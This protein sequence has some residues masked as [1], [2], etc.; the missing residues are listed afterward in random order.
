MLYEILVLGLLKSSES[1]SLVFSWSPKLTVGPCCSSPA[2]QQG[3]PFDPR[4][5]EICGERSGT[6]EIF[7]EYFGFLC[8]FSFHQLLHIH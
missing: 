1:K 4:S 5:C 2:S 3:Y 7:S 6:E 8:P